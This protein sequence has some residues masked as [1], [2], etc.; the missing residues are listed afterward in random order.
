VAKSK[1]IRELV[2]EL[3]LGLDSVVFVDDNPVECAE[4]E[5]HRCNILVTPS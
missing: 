1:N 4:V 2:E 3:S 5:V